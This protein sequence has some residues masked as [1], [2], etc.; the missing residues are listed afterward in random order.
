MARLS[1]RAKLGVTIAALAIAAVIGYALTGQTPAPAPAAPLAGPALPSAATASASA[2]AVVGAGK[3]GVVNTKTPLDK[4]LWKDL[5]PMQQQA[6][7][8]HAA[9]ITLGEAPAVEGRRPLA[10]DL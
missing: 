1:G 4:P 6:L 7:E 9:A 3:H 2:P 10:N 8:P 5:T